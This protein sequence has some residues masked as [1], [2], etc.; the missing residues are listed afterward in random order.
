MDGKPKNLSQAI[1][2]L[3]RAASGKTGE[4]RDRI[5]KEIHRLEETLKNLKPQ[6][7]EIQDRVSEEAKKAKGRVEEEFQKNPWTAVGIVGLI[8]FV[9]GFLLANRGGRGD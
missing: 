7:D 1:D 4:F 9:L 8:F 2:E 6:I 5:E 3:E